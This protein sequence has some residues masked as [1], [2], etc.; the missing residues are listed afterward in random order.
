MFYLSSPQGYT[1]SLESITIGNAQSFECDTLIYIAGD[2]GFFR[3]NGLNVTIKNYT[4]GAAAVNDLLEGKIDIAATAEF[5]LVRKAFDKQNIS[6]VAS[7]GKF[8]L[9]D[10]ICRKDRGIENPADL[11]G[12]TIGVPLGTISEFYLG[13]FLELHGIDLQNV[14]M[15][16]TDPAQSVT[17]ITNGSLDALIIWQ[18]YAYAAEEL[19]GENA[20][21]WIPQNNQMLFILEVAKNEWI[22]QHPDTVNRFI[23]SLAQA[24]EYFITHP[25]QV[26]DFMQQEL[27]YTDG[28]MDAIWYNNVYA[29]S[30][31]Q[32]LILAMEDEARWMINNHL[33]NEI[34][35]PDFLDYIYIDGLQSIK[36]EADFLNYIYLDGLQGVKPE[37]VNIIS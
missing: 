19:L 3:D 24:E 7:I 28:Y 8:Q 29:L 15:V 20:V 32:S 26:K 4:S 9:Q 5:P 23:E 11:K 17:A 33:T 35:I 31:D 18:P 21:S 2:Q 13:R 22:Q 25:S 16:N 1:G 36:P 6:A 12:K 34:T 10:L 14:T 27:N 37:A 30:L